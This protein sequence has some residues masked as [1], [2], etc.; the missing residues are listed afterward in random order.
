MSS[1]PSARRRK[2]VKGTAA[3]KKKKKRKKDENEVAKWTRKEVRQGFRR[4]NETGAASFTAVGDNVSTGKKFSRFF[5]GGLTRGDG[6]RARA[7]LDAEKMMAASGGGGGGRDGGD[8]SVGG[9]TD[10]EADGGSSHGDYDDRDDYD[11]EED[12]DREIEL[13][14]RQR[15]PPTSQK[16]M[17]KGKASVGIGTPRKDERQYAV[18]NRRPPPSSSPSSSG[19]GYAFDRDYDNRASATTSRTAS[20]LG[21]SS[22]SRASPG[23]SG[24]SYSVAQRERERA[25]RAR[26]G[27]GRNFAGTPIVS[28]ARSLDRDQ[29]TRQMS[30][31]SRGGNHFRTEEEDEDIRDAGMMEDDDD[32]NDPRLVKTSHLVVKGDDEEDDDESDDDEEDE[33]EFVDA[34]PMITTKKSLDRAMDEAAA[35]AVL[36]EVAAEARRNDEKTNNAAGP[37]RSLGERH[38]SSSVAGSQGSSPSSSKIDA[39]NDTT[40]FV[41]HTDRRASERHNVHAED[42]DDAFVDAVQ[43]PRPRRL[44]KKDKSNATSTSK[45]SFLSKKSSMPL[46]SS[47]TTTGSHAAGTQA[48]RRESDAPRR[49]LLAV[50]RRKHKKDDEKIAKDTFS[51]VPI[52]DDSKYTVH[53]QTCSKEVL[54]VEVDPAEMS[55]Y[56][57]MTMRSGVAPVTPQVL[58]KPKLKKIKKKA[59]RT[60]DKATM[61]HTNHGGGAVMMTSV[62]ARTRKSLSEFS[63]ADWMTIVIGLL[64]FSVLYLTVGSPLHLPTGL[65][66]ANPVGGGARHRVHFPSTLSVTVGTSTRADTVNGVDDT[67]SSVSV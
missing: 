30:S 65:F 11:E 15:P 49:K 16:T 32:R 39:A 43:D 57:T 24:S 22:R 5:R 46:A 35:A 67:E 13:Q 36:A 66:A 10:D 9:T 8:G 60:V 58:E 53:F 41:P 27:S 21:A 17:A 38:G 59:R 14:Q 64:L 1:S 31:S 47:A 40:G 7:F 55:A 63:A 50:K 3:A 18:T 4:M 51:L 23:S 29:Y 42:S 34:L 20:G 61:A 48:E 62:M 25:Y 56:A 26:T 19:S 44:K 12:M 52:E 28:S 54:S 2:S 45:L 33:D 6:R 37:S